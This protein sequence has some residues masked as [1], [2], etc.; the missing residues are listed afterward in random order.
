MPGVPGAGGVARPAQV[1]KQGVAVAGQG[2]LAPL[3]AHQAC[4]AGWTS[5][6]STPAHAAS[7]RS[8]SVSSRRQ[9][10]AALGPHDGRRRARPFVDQSAYGSPTVLGRHLAQVKAGYEQPGR[11]PAHRPPAAKTAWPAD[12]H[13][14]DRRRPVTVAETG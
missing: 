8:L 9:N 4:C 3:Q 12:R 11:E 14:P 6:S 5:D 2:A 1:R 10:E 7:L 13:R